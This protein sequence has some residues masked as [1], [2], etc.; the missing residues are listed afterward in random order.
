MC[1]I[2]GWLSAANTCASRRNRVESLRVWGEQLRQN[3]DRD[4]TVQIG[5]VCPI[6]LA[7]AADTNF[8]G[9]FVWAEPR[10]GGKGHRRAS[11]RGVYAD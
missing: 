1:A 8:G 9:H 11:R 2:L 10:A 7:H 4:V 3:F 6:D 5:V